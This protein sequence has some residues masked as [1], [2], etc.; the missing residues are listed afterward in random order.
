VVT[1][2]LALVD[3]PQL[4]IVRALLHTDPH[5]GVAYLVRAIGI[6]RQVLS[7]DRT[8]ISSIVLC[9]GILSVLTSYLGVSLD[10][11]YEVSTHAFPRIRYPWN[12]LR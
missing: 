9:L 3:P 10:R 6:L 4:D 5:T 7:R 12:T 11:L 2:L 8:L 1:A